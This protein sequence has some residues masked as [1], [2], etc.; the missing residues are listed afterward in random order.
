M[1]CTTINNFYEPLRKLI[2][3]RHA[4]RDM[5]LSMQGSFNLQQVISFDVKPVGS[6]VDWFLGVS[7]EKM[8]RMAPTHARIITPGVPL[9]IFTEEQSESVIDVPLVLS[10]Y[11]ENQY[12]IPG[13]E[14]VFSSFFVLK[15]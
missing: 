11:D 6:G 8:K 2:V 13:S 3:R 10:P 4:A 9:G 14:R 7:E 12:C 15:F 5:N 1:C